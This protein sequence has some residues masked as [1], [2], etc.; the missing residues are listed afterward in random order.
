MYYGGGGELLEAFYA[1]NGLVAFAAG[2]TGAQMGGWFRKEVRSVADMQGLKFR[3]SGITGKILAKIGTIA[4]AIP[5]ADVYPSLERGVIDAA[6][7]IGPYDDEKLGFVRVAPNYYYPGWWEGGVV[8]H[9]LHQQDEVGRAAK[10]VPGGSSSGLPSG[11]RRHAG[12]V[13]TPATQLR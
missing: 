9:T 4:Q 13:T 3:V 10:T 2:N 7:W 6:E 11:Q 5:A 8:V 1:K 12:E